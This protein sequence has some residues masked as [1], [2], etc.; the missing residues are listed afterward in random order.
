[1]EKVMKKYAILGLMLTMPLASAKTDVMKDA[2]K[3]YSE[4]ELCYLATKETESGTNQYCVSLYANEAVLNEEKE[5]HYKTY[6]LAVGDNFEKAHVFQDNVGLIIEDNGEGFE[7]NVIAQELFIDAGSSGYAPTD[8]KFHKIGFNSYGFVTETGDTAQ[9]VSQG[10][11]MVVG[12]HNGKIFDS[13]IPTFY[14]DSDH[15]ADDDYKDL[16]DIIEGNYEI[17]DNDQQQMYDIKVTLNGHYLGTEYKDQSYIMTFDEQ[18][19]QYNI[20]DDYPLKLL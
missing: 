8:Y 13:Y 7:S 14:D 18:M 20:P 1:M 6:Y 15:Y 10:G 17:M 2:Y 3:E 12:D 19:Q 9:G 4:S 5:G 16:S 11:I